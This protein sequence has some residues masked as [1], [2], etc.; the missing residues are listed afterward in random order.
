[1]NQI[2][3]STSVVSGVILSELEDGY[4]LLLMKRT[5]D[6]F[7]CHVAG[8]LEEHELA[9][10]AFVREVREETGLEVSEL[11]SAE[12][13]E[14]FYEPKQNCIHIIP[15]FVGL[16]SPGVEVILNQEHTEY[17]WCSLEE[18]DNLAPYANQKAL[19]HHV[20]TYFVKTRPHPRMRIAC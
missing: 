10:E 12:F 7:W 9:W 17:A 1:M 5:K 18:A 4:R 8:K 16:V 20:W 11:Y 2:P 14:Q 19:Y 3:I 13:L 6:E 15:A